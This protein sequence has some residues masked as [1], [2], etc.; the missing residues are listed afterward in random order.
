MNLSG[1][2]P[3]DMLRSDRSLRMLF[4][5]LATLV[6]LLLT[7]S[8]CAIWPVVFSLRSTG[9]PGLADAARAVLT[10]AIPLVVVDVLV[11]VALG[12]F[13]RRYSF[14]K[15]LLATGLLGFM[16]MVCVLF[17]MPVELS[18]GVPMTFAMQV[19]RVIFT[20]MLG[21]V[22]AFLPAL[23]STVLGFVVR[24]VYY[25]VAEMRR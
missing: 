20:L 10:A 18:A 12:W 6:M 21:G 1:L 17:A 3:W 23:V 16:V 25:V 19:L 15:S 8:S 7:V 24:E 13:D 22:L 5:A 14:L 2:F 4:T 11:A 9:E